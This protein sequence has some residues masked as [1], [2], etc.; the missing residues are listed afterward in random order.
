MRNV[1]L[2]VEDRGH[3]AFL[4]ALL[5]RFENQYGILVKIEYG[6][7]RGGHGKVVSELKK[8]I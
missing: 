5:K 2:F 3:Q 1:N 8:Y 6:N 7:G 4:E